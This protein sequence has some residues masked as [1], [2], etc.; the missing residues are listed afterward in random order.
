MVTKGLQEV[1]SEYMA[2]YEGLINSATKRNN[3]EIN[4]QLNKFITET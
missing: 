3:G 1:V 4:H 2:F